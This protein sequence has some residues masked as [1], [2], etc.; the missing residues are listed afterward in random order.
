MHAK[1]KNC[2][3][4]SENSDN[5]ILIR[6]KETNFIFAEA[7]SASKAFF[8]FQTLAKFSTAQFGFL[9][10]SCDERCQSLLFVSVLMHSNN[11]ISKQAEHYSARNV[12]DLKFSLPLVHLRL[13]HLRGKNPLEIFRK[14]DSKK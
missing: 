9:P 5:C 1:V 14:S 7:Q 11:D 6:R 2:N 12:V 10:A 13:Q 8:S 4:S 3:I